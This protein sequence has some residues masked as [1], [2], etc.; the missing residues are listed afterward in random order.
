PGASGGGQVELGQVPVA[1]ARS[2]WDLAQFD[3]AST[4]RTRLVRRLGL[5]W[6]QWMGSPEWRP[7]RWALAVLLVAQLAGLNAWAWK[8]RSALQAKRSQVRQI[9][10]QTFPRVPVVVD[11]P[12]QM[13]NEVAALRQATGAVSP[14]DLEPMLA[15]VADSARGAPAPGAIDFTRG[16][17][18]LKGFQPSPADAAG[19]PAAL[20]ATGYDAR[21][22]GDGWVIRSTSAA[23]GSQASRLRASLGA[24]SS[25]T[26]SSTTA[27]P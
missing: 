9:L 22:D 16:E 13:D 21:P 7:A 10:T 12:A 11:A 26:P 20:A 23:P 5:A 14:R 6:A 17:L 4:G 15:A 19:L 27:R 25:S 3:L 8:E 2:D 18:T 24:S 1:A